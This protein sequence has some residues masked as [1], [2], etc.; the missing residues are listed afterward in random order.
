MSRPPRPLEYRH[1]LL[2]AAADQFSCG[3]AALTEEQWPQVEA[4]AEQSFAL[5]TLV[6]S[7][8]EAQAVCIPD[9]QVEQALAAVRARYADE[10]EFTEE[11]AL[12][13]L[14]ISVLRRALQRELSFDAVIRAVGARHAPVTEADEQL[15]YELHTER[16]SQP[17]TRAARHLL[18]TVNEDYAE[19]Q[20]A[21][22]RARIEALAE[23]TKGND[24]DAFAELARRH[25]EC[26]TAL[27]DGRLGTMTPG[28]LYPAL[29]TALF[30]MAPGEV[31]A[32]LESPL[33]FHL[34]FCE[35]VTPAKTVPF[36]QARERIRQTL[37]DRRQRE[38]QKAWIAELRS[39]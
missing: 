27:E 17:E 11:L 37:T 29:D 10:Q 39:R 7:A 38:T 14:E 1:H 34:L 36:E 23:E 28:Q 9:D 19:N 13:G 8:P 31:S 4:R 33:G 32:V 30:A 18:I 12:N 35:A 25:S 24:V 16:F 6:L 26:P 3:L 21:A 5:E 15:F 20:R 22:A 2:R